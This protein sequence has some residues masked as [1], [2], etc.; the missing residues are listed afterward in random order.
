MYM[1]THNP[2]CNDGVGHANIDL[3]P[4]PPPLMVLAKAPV[5][6]SLPSLGM[7]C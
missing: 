7:N 2:L 5:V 4:P 1:V 6:K 3:M